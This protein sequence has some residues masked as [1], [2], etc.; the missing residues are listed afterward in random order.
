MSQFIQEFRVKNP[1]YNDMQDEQLVTALHKKYYSD[2]P[3]DQ[4]SQKIQF[5]AQPTIE[6]EAPSQMIQTKQDQSSVAGVDAPVSEDL[7]SGAI[8][9]KTTEIKRPQPRNEF[10]QK[11]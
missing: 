7:S 2:I 9:P 4:F 10:D 3:F 11:I 5:Q 1:Q 6:P 8:E